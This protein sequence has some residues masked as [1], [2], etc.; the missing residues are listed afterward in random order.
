MHSHE[1]EFAS[2]CEVW[3]LEPVRIAERLRQSGY[4][5]TARQVKYLMEKRKLK[6]SDKYIINVIM[7]ELKKDLQKTINNL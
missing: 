5:V 2:L 6:P 7:Q 3:G 1:V 4:N